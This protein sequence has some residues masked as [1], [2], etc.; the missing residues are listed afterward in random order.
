MELTGTP[1]CATK[2]VMDEATML[3]AEKSLIGSKGRVF[4]M[5]MLVATVLEV[6]YNRV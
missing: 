2:A 6:A 3:I 5:Y 4:D 1:G